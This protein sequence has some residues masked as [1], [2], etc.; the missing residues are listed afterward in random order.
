SYN[1]AT[2]KYDQVK[3]GQYT[4][5]ANTTDEW[6][7]TFTGLTMRVKFTKIGLGYDDNYEIIYLPVYLVYNAAWDGVYTDGSAQLTLDGYGIKATYTGS[8]SITGSFI[9]NDSIVTIID[10]SNN[11]KVFR[12]SSNNTFAVA[13]E[14]AGL[15]Y[16]FDLEAQTVSDEVQLFLDGLSTAKLIQGEAV[17]EGTYALLEDSEDEFE[18]T[19]QGVTFRF[20]LTFLQSYGFTVFTR[21]NETWSGEYTYDD[22]KIVLDGY[23]NVAY[24]DIYG[25]TNTYTCTVAGSQGTVVSF[26][27]DG[28]YYKTTYRFLL[29]KAAHTFERTY[30]AAGYYY[31]YDGE[32]ISG[33]KRVFL[34][35]KG[36][37]E[38]SAYNNQTKLYEVTASGTYAAVG[39][40]SSV[41]TFTPTSGTVQAFT[42]KVDEK[43]GFNVYKLSDAASGEFT[44]VVGEY[45]Y[46]FTADGFGSATYE[47]YDD[48]N[49][50]MR[51]REGEYTIEG[52]T[53]T[54]TIVDDRYGFVL[55][56]AVLIIDTTTHTFTIVSQG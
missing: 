55:F 15:H 56:E 48:Y 6:T 22:Q 3:T 24:T 2:D 23:G 5:F 13:D 20:K 7:V 9:V 44:C 11:R 28:Y 26:Q 47:Y 36:N 16:S 40:S 1:E 33:Y 21:Y 12:I 14:S 37:A 31:F 49:E 10:S 51:K 53:V 27:V 29:D 17:T 54:F 43:D 42:F 8:E 35:G 4:A 41:F 45:T 39:S 52:N 19:A 38:I 50:E 18:F 46:K 32:T 34:D 25:E 30:E